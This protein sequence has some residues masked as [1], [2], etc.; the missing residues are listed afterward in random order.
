M[1]F[2][3]RLTSLFTSSEPA[4][5]AVR[6]NMMFVGRARLIVHLFDE[7]GEEASAEHAFEQPPGYEDLL[8][9]EFAPHGSRTWWTYITAGMSLCPALDHL[10]PTE[11]F[12]Y[13]EE[14]APGLID[15]LN[16]LAVRP[17][18]AVAYAVA[19]MAHFDEDPP[20][21][22]IPLGRH[23]G[24][25]QA[26]ERPEVLDFPNVELRSEDLRFVMARPGEDPVRFLR[27]LALADDDG[28]RFKALIAGTTE[29]RAWEIL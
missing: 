27:V 2:L 19:D 11:L 12:A 7:F 24:F 29:R 23:Y 17:P 26:P 6:A 13:S 8:F 3:D 15:V 25:V 14:Q 10:P 18:E 22:G 1:G 9:F 16:Q 28:E 21:L 4:P 20:D 5:D